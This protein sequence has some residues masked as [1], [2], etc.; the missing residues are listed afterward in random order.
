MIQLLRGY[1]R[2]SAGRLTR[3]LEKVAFQE[4]STLLGGL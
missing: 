4:A 2:I 1:Y 3:L